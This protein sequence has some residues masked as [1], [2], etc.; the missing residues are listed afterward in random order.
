MVSAEKPEGTIAGTRKWI[1]AARNRGASIG[2]V[3]TMGA[4]HGGHASLIRLARR[5]CASVVVSIFVNPTQFG[6]SED[7]KEYPRQLETDMQLC[8]REGVE[9][10]FAPQPEE[11]YPEGFCS[12]VEVTGLQDV[13]CGASRPGHFR[14]V[15]TVVAKLLGIVQPNRAYFGQKDAQQA[16]IVQQLALDLNMATE[17]VIGPTI[18]E[19]DGLALSSRNLYL[20]AKQRESARVLY[21]ALTWAKDRIESGE[22]DAAKLKVRIE[23]LI[24]ATPGAALDYVGVVDWQRLRPLSRMAGEVLIAVAV[25]FGDT[26]LIDNILVSLPNK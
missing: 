12:F 19:P 10:V 9:F 17:I 4:L 8:E 20:D 7:Y 22:R 16:R 13:L 15:A 3:P 6:P 5:E 1:A 14:G 2:L 26:R 21:R 18:R 24:K 23:D 11:M 25:R